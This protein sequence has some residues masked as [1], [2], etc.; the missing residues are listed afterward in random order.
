MMLTTKMRN[1][2]KKIYYDPQHPAAFGSEEKLYLAVKPKK[3]GRKNVQK[4]LEEQDTHTLHR[5]IKRKFLRRKTIARHVDEIW[6]ADLVDV[7]AIQKDNFGFRYILTVV[8]ILSRYAFAVPIKSKTGLNITNAFK[9]IFRK[10]KRKPEKLQTDKG[11]EFYNKTFNKFLTLKKIYHYSTESEM[12]GAI[13]E[14][15]NRTLQ[16]KMYKY[17]TSRKTLHFIRVLPKLIEAYNSRVHG[18][19]KMKPK[20][21]TRRRNEKQAWVRMYG[22]LITRKKSVSKNKFKIGDT[23]R[24]SKASRTFK[25]GYLK[26]W[27][28]EVFIVTNVLRKT[29]PV[30]YKLSDIRGEN[31]TGTFYNEELNRVRL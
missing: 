25:K 29:I 28:D 1:V 14:R 23:V 3:I 2:L 5:T 10:Y 16:E 18:A 27:T 19:H 13:V 7:Q 31:I 30:T 22:D 15:F 8:D 6:V 9:K 20:Q 26:G 11:L 12:K 24:I 17:F 4:F 21:V